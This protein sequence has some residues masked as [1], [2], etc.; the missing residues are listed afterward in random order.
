MELF[1]NCAPHFHGW[2][3]DHV[4][5]VPILLTNVTHV[6]ISNYPEYSPLYIIG[7][8]SSGG[9]PKVNQ[10]IRKLDAGAYKRRNTENINAARRKRDV[11][12]AR[13]HR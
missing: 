9:P 3:F 8:G 7:W 11:I 6:R 13:D 2:S 5:F 12:E 4:T 10:R 1:H